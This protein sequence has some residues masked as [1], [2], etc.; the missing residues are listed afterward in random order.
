ME[1][2]KLPFYLGLAFLRPAEFPL[3]GGNRIACG[4][5]IDQK[6]W[7]HLRLSPPTLNWFGNGMTGDG[8]LL[9]QPNPMPPMMLWLVWPK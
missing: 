6:N 2:Q 5:N 8:D 7:L 3:S 9:Q 1:T 4:A